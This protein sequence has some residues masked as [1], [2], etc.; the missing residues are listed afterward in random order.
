MEEEAENE[1][2]KRTASIN[3]PIRIRPP[4]G[5]YIRNKSLEMVDLPAP[6]S[7]CMADGKEKRQI[8]VIVCCVYE[9][10]RA[11]VRE[12]ERERESVCMCMHV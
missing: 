4:V 11:R 6:L 1:N 7:L 12:R 2:Q 10:E 9:R 3:E 8:S 5:S